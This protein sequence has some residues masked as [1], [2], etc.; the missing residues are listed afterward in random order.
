MS[1]VSG[2]EGLAT[3]SGQ[4]LRDI[5]KL[6]LEMSFPPDESTVQRA[7][8]ALGCVLACMHADDDRA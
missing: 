1:R 8:D 5:R 7:Q 4:G 3:S 2:S 6:L